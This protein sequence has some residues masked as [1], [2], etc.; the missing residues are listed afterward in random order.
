MS[1]TPAAVSPSRERGRVVVADDHGLLREALASLLAAAGYEVVG[2][3]GDAETLLAAVRSL[4]PDLVIVDVRMPPTFTTEGLAA[5][6][7]IR[8]DF[9]DVGVLMLSAFLDVGNVLQ[10][11]GPGVG[12]S[13]QRVGYLLKSR[14]RDGAELVDA[15]ERVSEGKTVIDPALVDELIGHVHRGDPLATLSARDRQVLALMAEGRSNVGIAEH[16]S[17]S[18][19]AVEKHVQRIVTRLDI[20]GGTADNRRVLAVLAYLESR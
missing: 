10:L 17:I 8:A 11:L 1:G 20:P 15:L 16:L 7:A 9:P 3:A 2:Q 19:S 13:T 18:T 5:A 6:S 12:R 14:V 4:E